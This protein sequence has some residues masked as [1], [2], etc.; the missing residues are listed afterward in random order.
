MIDYKSFAMGAIAALL[1]S[2]GDEFD[3]WMSLEGWGYPEPKD[4]NLYCNGEV[5]SATLYPVVDGI[6]DTTGDGEEIYRLELITDPKT[7]K[8]QKTTAYN[9]ITQKGDL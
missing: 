3:I 6:I 7:T 1:N 9:P 2:Q 8:P 4:I 5:A